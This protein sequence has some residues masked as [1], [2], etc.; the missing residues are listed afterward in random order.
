MINLILGQ[1]DPSSTSLIEG[2][3]SLLTV[4][5]GL[6]LVPGFRGV[7]LSYR[8]QN[9]VILHEQVVVSLMIFFFF[10][11]TISFVIKVVFLF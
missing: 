8:N 6:N 1:M 5:S 3:D 7:K 10:C 9:I 4:D 11:V 2:V